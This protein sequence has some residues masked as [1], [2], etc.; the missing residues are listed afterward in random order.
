MA[1]QENK[2][3]IIVHSAKY[4]TTY[5]KKYLNR[6]VWEEPNFNMIKII[7]SGN[8]HRYFGERRTGFEW[9]RQYYC[10]GGN[11]NVQRC[12]DAVQR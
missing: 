11:E 3:Y 1:D 2:Q 5:N 4:E 10:F 12:A 7:Y 9:W 6:K 8:D